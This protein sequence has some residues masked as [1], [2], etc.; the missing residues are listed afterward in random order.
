[1]L[2][3]MRTRVRLPLFDRSVSSSDPE[4]YRIC[5]FFCS[6]IIQE[7]RP[8][9]EVP[10]EKG[11]TRGEESQVGRDHAWSPRRPA[12]EA[13][14]VRLR[15]DVVLLGS[16]EK[17]RDGRGGEFIVMF[18]LLPIAN[19]IVTVLLS[20]APLK[21]G[22]GRDLKRLAR[23]LVLQPREQASIRG[24]RYPCKALEQRWR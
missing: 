14:G 19:L 17:R 6:R 9:K 7:V 12:G 15:E 5:A 22:W 24:F 1:M 20:S 10:F 16:R 11:S 18:V 4:F 2:V 3:F 8:S 13:Q 23:V 21:Q